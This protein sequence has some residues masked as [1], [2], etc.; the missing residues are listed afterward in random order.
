MSDIKTRM[1]F[2]L[3]KLEP[4]FYNGSNAFLELSKDE[5]VHFRQKEHTY[6]QELNINTASANLK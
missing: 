6:K 1:K 5:N 3:I 4:I 2:S